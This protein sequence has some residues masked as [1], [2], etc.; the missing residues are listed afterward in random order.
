MFTL[1][2]AKIM[3]S[4]QRHEYVSQHKWLSLRYVLFSFQCPYGLGATLFLD[5]GCEDT[6]L[7][8]KREHLRRAQSDTDRIEVIRVEVDDD[9]LP[10]AIVTDTKDGLSVDVV[11]V[12]HDRLSRS[13]VLVV[14]A[15]PTFSSQ[16]SERT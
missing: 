8:D 16:T 9:V 6:Q 15:L 3:F 7:I 11:D 5:T 13:S 12:I 14:L 10:V 4:G 1:S 2:R